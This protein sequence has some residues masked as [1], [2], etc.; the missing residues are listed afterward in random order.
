VRAQGKGIAPVAQFVDGLIGPV[1]HPIH[2]ARVG[3][4]AAQGIAAV[5]GLPA[6]I[7]IRRNVPH[8]GAGRRGRPAGSAIA[9]VRQDHAGTGTGGGDGGPGA[10]R[11]AAQHQ[12]VRHEFPI[13]VS[14]GGPIGRQ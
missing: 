3:Q 12:H 9:L 13:G 1:E 4:E 7:R 8:A 10:C 2:P 6:Q 5:A 14:P 11:A